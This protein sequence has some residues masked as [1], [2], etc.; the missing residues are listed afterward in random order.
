MQ[1]LSEATHQLLRR[2]F[3]LTAKTSWFFR[4]D[5]DAEI[6]RVLEQIAEQGEPGAMSGV[7]NCLFSPSAEVRAAASRAIHHLLG[8]MPPEQLRNLGEVVGRSWG[9]FIWDAWEQLTP[10]GVQTLITEESTRTSVLGLLSFHR[11]G[12]VRHEAL[13]LL[14][15]G[16]DG[17]E[18]PYL[19]IRQNDW[20]EQI[21]ADAQDAVRARLEEVYLPDFVANLPLVVHLLTLRRRDH[22]A[23]VRQVIGMLVQ[24]KHDELLARSIHSQDREVRRSVVRLALDAE[25]EHRPR[26][27]EHALSSMDGVIRLWGSRLVRFCFSGKALEGIL[28]SLKRDGFIPVR[29]EA[30]ICQADTSL[31]CGRGVWRE[32]LLDGNASIR[33]LARFHLGKLGEVHWPEVYRRALM[34]QPRSLAALGGLSETGDRSDL[35]A[36]R[37]FLAFPL[38]GRRRAAV[39][40]LARLGGKSVVTELHRYIQD[41]SPAVVREAQKHLEAYPVELDG[42]WLCR[43]VMDDHRHKVRETALRLINAMGKWPSLPWLIRAST[44][45]DRPTAELAERLVEAWFTPPG[46]NRVFTRPSHPER[47]AIIETLDQSRQDLAETFLRKL[48]LWLKHS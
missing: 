7:A 44:H 40:A 34:E 10:A 1:Q 28:G 16:H 6:V 35:I 48:E 37:V 33:E 17:S 39:R 43:M 11:N 24:P 32:A 18:L 46:C 27:V 31:D 3:D 5:R 12:Y 36:I 47:Q 25:G 41:D 9:W 42:E 21:R 4:H 19:L 26:V 20:V 2:L 8:R 14:A 30:L 45:R 29:R 23:L 38:P 15:Q 22:A 13:R